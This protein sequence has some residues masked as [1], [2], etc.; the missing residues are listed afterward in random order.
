MPFLSK[1]LLR[2]SSEALWSPVLVMFS[3]F[4]FMHAYAKTWNFACEWHISFE[5]YKEDINNC[6]WCCVKNMHWRLCLHCHLN[7]IYTL[8]HWWMQSSIPALFWSTHYYLLY[9]VTV[10]LLARVRNLFDWTGQ[11][12]G[13]KDCPGCPW[14]I[15]YCHIRQRGVYG[16]LPVMVWLPQ[17]R[18]FRRKQHRMFLPQKRERDVKRKQFRM[19][20]LDLDIVIRVSLYSL[21][22]LAHKFDESVDRDD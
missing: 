1:V 5:Y 7:C 21:H 12:L 3:N 20:E 13:M 19:W 6:F 4:Q 17:R 10:T 9:T 16:I 11:T 22:W 14:P 18:V 2:V 8:L 15:T